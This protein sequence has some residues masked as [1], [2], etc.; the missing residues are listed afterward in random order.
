MWAMAL[1]TKDGVPEKTSFL[2][3]ETTIR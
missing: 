2:L 3:T 1:Q